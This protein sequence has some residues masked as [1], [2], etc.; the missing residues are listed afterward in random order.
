[1]I[2]V[3]VMYPNAED[4]I[5]DKEYYCNKHIPLVSEL[6]GDALKNIQVSF[7]LTGGSAEEAP[8]FFA[9]VFMTFDS[10]ESFQASFGP[11]AER[12]VAD[13]PNYTNSQ[14]QIQIS[15]IITK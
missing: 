10:V 2:N 7:G 13:I 1:M 9:M 12:L 6:L 15:E 14:A 4:I 5:F 3:S 11:H 8:A